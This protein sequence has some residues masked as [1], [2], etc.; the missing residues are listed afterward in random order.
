MEVAHIMGGEKCRQNYW[1]FK[2]TAV[3]V[4]CISVEG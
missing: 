4:K 3:G 2:D 1:V